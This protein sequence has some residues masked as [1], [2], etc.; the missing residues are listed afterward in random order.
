[1]RT[2][3]QTNNKTFENRFIFGQWF[4]HTI[5]RNVAAAAVGAAGWIHHHRK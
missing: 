5:F 1:M 2:S 4:S 3:K